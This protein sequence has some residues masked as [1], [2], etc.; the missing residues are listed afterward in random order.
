MELSPGV[1][2]G[3]SVLLAILVGSY[4]IS[5][6]FSLHFGWSLAV[7][8]VLF[9]ILGLALWRWRPQSRKEEMQR[10]H[11]A[12][13]EIARLSLAEARAKAL[14]LLEDPEK[15]EC[16]RADTAGEL[17]PRLPPS[18]K[19]LFSLFTSVKAVAGEGNLSIEHVADSA[20]RPTLI[21]IGESEDSTELAVR[22]D[23]DPVY[24]IDGSD[25]DEEELE[26]GGL[27]SVFH[28]ILE[29]DEV[30]YGE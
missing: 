8:G 28:W 2:Y 25:A 7:T 21:R 14:K 1:Q 30:L 24:E 27:P 13:E 19:E 11:N 17:D 12:V 5:D 9:G 23:E 26:E 22:P 18:A 4:A 10:M 16:R 29:T 6:L 3:A 20:Y 15:F